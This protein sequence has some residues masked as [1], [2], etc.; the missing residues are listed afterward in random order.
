MNN[1]KRGSHDAAAYQISSKFA[2]AC[3]LPRMMLTDPT[4]STCM[5]T[6]T[7][8]IMKLYTIRNAMLIPLGID[9]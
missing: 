2:M 6:N 3:Q 7:F 8:L 9:V 5:Q 1:L 4:G